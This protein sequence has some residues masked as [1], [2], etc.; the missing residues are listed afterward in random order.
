MVNA[1]PL[2]FWK[3]IAGHTW[4]QFK[5]RLA[6]SSFVCICLLSKWINE[7][8]KQMMDNL[9]QIFD[10]LFTNSSNLYLEGIARQ[11]NVSI[12]PGSTICEK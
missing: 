5:P 6:L 10:W 4:W 1:Y 7:W 8:C 9:L 2:A 3:S 11:E 12:Y